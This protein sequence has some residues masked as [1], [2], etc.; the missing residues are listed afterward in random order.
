[1]EYMLAW[2]P[3]RYDPWYYTIPR[4]AKSESPMTWK[5]NHTQGKNNAKI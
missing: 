3:L 5:K 1:M 4:I 2:R